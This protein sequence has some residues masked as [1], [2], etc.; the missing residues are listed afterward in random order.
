M[1]MAT[2]AARAQTASQPPAPGWRTANRAANSATMP[3]ATPP[4]P[5]TAVKDP[6]RSKVRRMYRRLSMARSCNST[7]SVWGAAITLDDSAGEAE[8]QVLFIIKSRGRAKKLCF[9]STLVNCWRGPEGGILSRGCP[10]EIRPLRASTARLG[11]AA[12]DSGGGFLYVLRPDR[13][14]DLDQTAREQDFLEG[15]FPRA[16]IVARKTGLGETAA[17][18]TAGS[19]RRRAD[20]GAVVRPEDGSDQRPDPVRF[21]CRRPGRRQDL[22]R[23]QEQGQPHPRIRGL[24]PKG[25]GTG[26]DRR[27]RGRRGG[28]LPEG[29]GDQ[30]GRRWGAGQPGHDLL[31][32]PQIRGGR[33]VLS[34][35]HR[36]GPR[37]SAGA[38]QPGQ[39]VRRA[40]THCGSSGLLPARARAE[41]ALRRRALQPG[42]AVRTSGRC[43][44]GRPPLEGLPEAGQ[45]RTMGRDRPPSAGTLA[46]SGSAVV[47]GRCNSV[48][49][50]LGCTRRS[51]MPPCYP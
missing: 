40:G 9:W 8:F 41:S 45:F 24:V 48:R 12:P 44:Q 46:A 38:I 14:P 27:A 3:M 15:D 16:G 6:A 4:M 33:E 7:G 18:R 19:V 49:A 29:V 37:I 35:R 2:T 25:P 50:S 31:P 21:R 30:P 20:H 22:S 11:A 47:G 26:G 1:A 32:S 10:A 42:A 5:G 36:G 17:Q 34:G 28:R 13:F 51:L 23:A 43:P 39:P